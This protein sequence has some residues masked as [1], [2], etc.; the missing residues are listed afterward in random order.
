MKR[1]DS[2]M[3][4][5]HLRKFVVVNYMT[6]VFRVITQI[7]FAPRNRV[8]YVRN[9]FKVLYTNSANSSVKSGRKTLI[10]TGYVS[11]SRK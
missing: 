11:S 2:K 7:V 5:L 4:R 3:N 6:G 9:S 8:M 10:V 1:V